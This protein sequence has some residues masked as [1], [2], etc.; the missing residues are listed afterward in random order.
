MIF[1]TDADREKRYTYA[2]ARNI[3]EIREREGL[4]IEQFARRCDGVAGEP[5]RFKPNTL[6]ALFAGKRKNITA[7]E[8][9]VFSKA[10][11]VPLVALL[12]PILNGGSFASVAHKDVSSFH[13]WQRVTGIGLRLGDSITSFEVAHENDQIVAF[14][15]SINELRTCIYASG[16]LHA[17]YHGGVTVMEEH[18]VLERTAVVALTTCRYLLSGFDRRGFSVDEDDIAIKWCRALDPKELT[19]S[20]MT[21]LG[22]AEM[23]A[24]D[25]GEP[26]RH[27]VLEP[28]DAKEREERAAAADS[29]E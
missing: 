14:A 28:I 17:D 19:I 2:V 8:L 3:A 5:G 21:E 13:A 9:A 18:D 4:T 25:I 22:W 15:N 29:A 27:V 1:M 6:Q 26:V 20:V 7:Y 10:L 16:Y 12:A 24:G 11:G 23:T